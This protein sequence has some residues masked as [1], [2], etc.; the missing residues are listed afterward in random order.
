M[1]PYG[2]LDRGNGAFRPTRV[3]GSSACGFV[4]EVV[5]TRV[6][7]R[8]PRSGAGARVGAGAGGHPGRVG[9]QAPFASEGGCQL[10]VWANDLG[11]VGPKAPFAGL[12]GALRPTR[13]WEWGLSAHS[14]E[15]RPI[16]GVRACRECQLRVREWVRV[17]VRGR[18][19]VRGSPGAYLMRPV[20]PGRVGRKAPFVGLKGALRP[21][22]RAEWGLTAHSAH[23]AGPSRRPAPRI[24][25]RIPTPTPRGG[26][27]PRSPRPCRRGRRGS[28]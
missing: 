25:T 8:G 3:R 28:R 21:T 11:R 13:S 2:R 4:R 24:Q 5:S 23:S 6:W 20:P 17:R 15:E 16:R 27:P 22:Q 12:N 9:R 26:D 10:S 18:S 14:G 1:G 7:A 19:D